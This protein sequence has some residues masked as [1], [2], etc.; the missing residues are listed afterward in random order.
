MLL[1]IQNQLSDVSHF[2]PLF[3]LWAGVCVLFFYGE[4][5][6]KVVPGEKRQKTER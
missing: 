4:L 3:Q 2:A 6:D 1:Q 5:L